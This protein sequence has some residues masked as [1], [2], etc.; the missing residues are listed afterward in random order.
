MNCLRSRRVH[1][2]PF[3]ISMPPWGEG[4]KWEHS[5]HDHSSLP[6]SIHEALHKGLCHPRTPSNPCPQAPFSLHHLRCFYT[7]PLLFF[8]DRFI[9]KQKHKFLSPNNP[10]DD[11]ICFGLMKSIKLMKQ[12]CVYRHNKVL[13]MIFVNH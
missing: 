6:P 3:M 7:W 11:F 4:R 1:S 9:T 10:L 8:I 12:V 5:E 13:E 2:G